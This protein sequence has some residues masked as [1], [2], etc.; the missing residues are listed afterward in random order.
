MQ[1]TL[2]AARVNAGLTIKEA[3]AKIGVSVGT[4][5][6]Y[7]KGATYPDVARLE[8][9]ERLYGADYS[10]IKFCPSVTLKAEPNRS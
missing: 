10:S 6:N 2:K 5:R 7:E 4:L 9:I 1:I 3:A 8:A